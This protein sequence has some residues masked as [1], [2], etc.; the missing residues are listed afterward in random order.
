AVTDLLTEECGLTQQSIIADIG[1]G[2]GILSELFLKNENQVLGVEP[3]APM[4]EAGERLLERY[5][6]FKSIEGAAEA[7]TLLDDSVDF[8]SAG[9]AFHW[10]DQ[11]LAR[12]EFS[13]ILKPSGC[14][15]LI[16]NERRIDST[17]FLRAYEQIL[18]RRASVSSDS[19]K[20][21]RSST[22]KVSKAVRYPCPTRPSQAV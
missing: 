8:V 15:V 1:S 9:Q 17:P 3:N 21:S 7:T 18:F 2:T 19:L 6:K 16:W 12:D 10:F 11:K 13:R 20:T 5:S 4:R 22:S 14:V